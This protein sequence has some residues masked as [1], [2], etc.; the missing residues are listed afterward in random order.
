MLASHLGAWWLLRSGRLLPAVLT[1]A[2]VYIST[3][4]AVLYLYGGLRSPATFVLSPIVL[5]VGLTWS[6]RAATAAA[7][8]CSLGMLA[9]I[10]LQVSE[11]RSIRGGFTY[12]VV[13]TAVLFLTSVVLG[14]A[15]RAI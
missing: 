11:G 8:A 7:T 13:A 1:H 12:W 6:G 5:L 10:G 14:V 2:T 3:I 9:M 15:L 4:L